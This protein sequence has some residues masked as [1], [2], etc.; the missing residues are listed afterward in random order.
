MPVSVMDFKA[1]C[2]KA[3]IA[4]VIIFAARTLAD[5]ACLLITD[6][7]PKDIN[8]EIS[9]CLQSLA[10]LVILYGLAVWA[11]ARV[12]G[13]FPGKEHYRKPKRLGKAVSWA[14]P[15]YGAGQTANIIVLIISFIFVHNENAVQET[16]KPATSSSGSG[17]FYLIFLFIQMTVLAP[18]FEEYWFRGIIQTSLAPFGNMFSIAV[19]SLCFAMAHGNIHQFC[20]CL[21]AGV[22]FGYV[23]YASGS[24]LPT[25]IIHAIFNSISAI[26]LVMVNNDLFVSA[27]TKTTKRIALTDAEQAMITVLTVYV[28]AV[29]IFVVVGIISAIT[30]LKN[31]RLYRPADNCPEISKKQKLISLCTSPFFIIGFI[32]CA[33]YIAVFI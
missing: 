33:A 6:I 30:K 18:L 4:L 3:G 21:A 26:I 11:T 19:S 12:F 10:S 8:P 17:V 13:F 15:T 5:L 25:T 16:F 1:A 20:Y 29:L 31:N 22:F 7:L 28:I 32:L 23:R 14:V 9:A 24:L 2:K 27:I